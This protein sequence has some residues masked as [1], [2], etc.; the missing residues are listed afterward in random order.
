MSIH[1]GLYIKN[2]IKES[3][4]SI[5]ELAERINVGRNTVYRWMDNEKLS[6][7]KMI[8]IAKA[9]D[10]DISID[11]PEV[12]RIEAEK[13]KKLLA[14]ESSD[15]NVTMKTKYM[16]LLEKHTFLLEELSQLKE[17]MAKY[18]SQSKN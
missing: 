10:I 15:D 18:K 9:I 4:Y 1:R 17:E 13:R 6:L 7:V 5:S 11:F 12:E 16:L 2:L 3:E 8:R 14:E